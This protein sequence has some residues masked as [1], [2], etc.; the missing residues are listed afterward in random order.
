MPLRKEHTPHELDR[1][2]EAIVTGGDL[3][4]VDQSYNGNERHARDLQRRLHAAYSEGEPSSELDHRGGRSTLGRIV[5]LPPIAMIITGGI[6]VAF[7]LTALLLVLPALI[8]EASV[9][10]AKPA[11]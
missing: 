5:S 1:S 3:D 10:K 11:L 9:R 7:V 2:E 8:I 4:V 6:Y